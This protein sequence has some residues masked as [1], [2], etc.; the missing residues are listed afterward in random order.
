MTQVRSLRLAHAN[1]TPLSSIGMDTIPNTAQL[2]KLDL[3]ANTVKESMRMYHPLGLNI[4]EARIDAVLPVGGGP[5][6]K[7]PISV[8][9][10]QIIGMEVLERAPIRR[11][12]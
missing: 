4:R 3:L 7:G 6:G 9:A 1:P 5:D 11:P 8:S 2:R 12:R 10:G